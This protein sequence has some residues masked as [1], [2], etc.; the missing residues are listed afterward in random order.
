MTPV[1]VGGPS[2]TPFEADGPGALLPSAPVVRRDDSD[3][4]LA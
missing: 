4:P 2:G 1:P 3:G